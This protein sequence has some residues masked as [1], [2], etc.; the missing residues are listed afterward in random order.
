MAK[1]KKETKQDMII[2]LLKEVL[3]EL[4]KQNE[5]TDMIQ[6]RKLDPSNKVYDL[7]TF[8]VCKRCGAWYPNYHSCF[9]RYGTN[10]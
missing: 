3:A 6:K 2:R 10:N 1:L 7:S 9:N 4:K 5:K 8:K